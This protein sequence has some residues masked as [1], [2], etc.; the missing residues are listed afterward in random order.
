MSA[1]AK[2]DARSKP[3]AAK[4][5]E[6]GLFSR[7]R[8][9]R[10]Q[11]AYSLVSSLG[12]FFQ[13]PFATLLTV[14][15]M[16]VAIALPL[17]LALTL[18]NIDRFSGHV[19]ESREVTVFL[20]TDV[21]AAGADRIATELRQ[22][23]DVAEVRVK[24]PA[25]GLAEFRQMS[26]LAG[27]IDALQDNPMPTVLVA[28]PKDEG[29]ALA[30]ALKQRPEVDLVQHDAVWR[31]RLNAWLAFGGRVT[32][33]IAVLL[34]LGVLLVVGNTIRLEIGARRDEIGVLQQL[35][36]TDGFVRRPF[37]YLGAWYGAAAGALALGLLALAGMAVQPPLARLVGSYG[38]QFSL[39]GPGWQGGVAILA[40]A[41]AF[42]WLGAWLAS[43]HH[44]RQTRPTDL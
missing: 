42:G 3:A 25:E 12:R 28:L 34:G 27:A 32:W 16:A 9:W 24:T 13:R 5:V 44:L 39:A 36:A 40:T 15:V 14:G 26:E 2:A 4:R 21:D 31:E 6:S 23:P 8:A 19:R 1:D 41:I 30:N 29:V 33:V 20:K 35:G 7:L 43:G 10:E 17:G 11:H 37:L 38:S 22:R 18:A